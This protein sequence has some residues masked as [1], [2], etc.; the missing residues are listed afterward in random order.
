MLHIYISTQKRTIVNET[1]SFLTDREAGGF[2]GITA[3]VFT[4]YI[5]ISDIKS[6]LFAD[7]LER[8]RN[9]LRAGNL[10]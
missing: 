10:V 6:R 9:C 7:G 8:K 3:T 2:N 1:K 5:V 4:G